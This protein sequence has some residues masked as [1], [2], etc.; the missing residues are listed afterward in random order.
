VGCALA[1]RGSTCGTPWECSGTECDPVCSP[2][3]PGLFSI[4]E[5]YVVANEETGPELWITT[6]PG[7][8]AP[9]GPNPVGERCDAF[10]EDGVD[11]AE[12]LIC[13]YWG[14]VVMGCDGECRPPGTECTLDEDC[15]DGDVCVHGYCEWCCPG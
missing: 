10:E 4:I 5:G 9:P 7:E 15:T 11:C 13:Y 8:C 14:D 1:L 3:S 6:A 12:G 2:T